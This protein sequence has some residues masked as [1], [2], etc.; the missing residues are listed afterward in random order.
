MLAGPR[1]PPPVRPQSGRTRAA[2]AEHTSNTPPNPPEPKSPPAVQHKDSTIKL[3]CLQAKSNLQLSPTRTKKQET[4]TNDYKNVSL[5]PIAISYLKRHDIG[6][7]GWAGQHYRL[8]KCPKKLAV[9]IRAATPEGS[10]ASPSC[11]TL[12][13]ATEVFL[14][15]RHSSCT[16]RRIIGMSSSRKRN[17]I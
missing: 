2:L 16:A 5:H 7:Y 8:P 10:P 14:R 11:I 13:A 12:S 9:R 4:R 1:D 3:K 17:R 15:P 6:N